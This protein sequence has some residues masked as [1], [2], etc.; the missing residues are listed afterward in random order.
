[1]RHFK[2]YKLLAPLSTIRIQYEFYIDALEKELIRGSNDAWRARVDDHIPGSSRP[3]PPPGIQGQAV[4]AVQVQVEQHVPHREKNRCVAR[5][6]PEL[7]LGARCAH[8]P[9]VVHHPPTSLTHHHHCLLLAQ[10]H[11]S[12]SHPI[13]V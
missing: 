13:L 8:P 1:M 4:P 12:S 9:G 3:H 5:W 2:P 11:P 7:H 10:H 6:W